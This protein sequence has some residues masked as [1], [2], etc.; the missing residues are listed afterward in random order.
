MENAL[1]KMKYRVADIMELLR[2]KSVFDLNQV[3]FAIIETNRQLSVPKKAEY[4]PLTAKDMQI[5]RMIS[6]P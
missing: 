4:E 5:K 3:D 2:N 1:R 6:C